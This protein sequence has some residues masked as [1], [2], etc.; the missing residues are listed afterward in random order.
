MFGPITVGTGELQISSIVGTTKRQR[1]NMIYVIG[2]TN[3]GPAVSAPPTLRG[4][5]RKNVGRRKSAIGRPFLRSTARLGSA[6]YFKMCP[7]IGPSISPH[8]F[9]VLASVCS[10]VTTPAMWARKIELSATCVEPIFIGNLPKLFLFTPRSIADPIA[11]SLDLPVGFAVAAHPRFPLLSSTV[12]W[13]S[14]TFKAFTVRGSPKGRM[15]VLAGLA[16]SI[17]FGSE[18]QGDCPLCR[19]VLAHP[20]TI[21]PFRTVVGSPPLNRR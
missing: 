20:S 2:T 16:R 8:L 7:A 11:L 3:V 6:A 14:F 21:P 5:N 9:E 13:R 17:E 4:P 1:K 12:G 18:S 10:R 15:A 19:N